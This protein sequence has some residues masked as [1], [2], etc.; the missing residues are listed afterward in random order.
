M[1]LMESIKVN[2]SKGKLMEQVHTAVKAYILKELLSMEIKDK[3]NQYGEKTINMYI[4]E[5]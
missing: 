2:L 3:D 1:I 5:I 4:K